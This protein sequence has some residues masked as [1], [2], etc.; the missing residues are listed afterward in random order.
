MKKAVIIPFLAI[1]STVLRA[2]DFT[3]DLS[4]WDS[5]ILKEARAYADHS[6]ATEKSNDVVFYCNLARM[7]GGLFIETVL[8]PYLKTKGDT[9]SSRYK[10]SL[11]TRLNNLKPLP[12]LRHDV[13]LIA[14]AKS[15]ANYTGRKGIV[16]HARFKKRFAGLVAQG[17]TVGEN[18]SY[19]MHTALDVV[20]QLLI[21][22]GVPDLGHRN[23]IL[24]SDFTKVGVAFAKHKKYGINT[25][26]EFSN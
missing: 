13:T 19:G 26:M 11:I 24:S 4:A 15:Y 5:N 8:Q 22:E 3:P 18:C 16:G 7:N 20:I 9:R 14:M 1:L 10:Q 25:V 6:S 2:Q 23:N 12:P 17:K 21:D